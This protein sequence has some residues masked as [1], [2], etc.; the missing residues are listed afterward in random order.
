MSATYPRGVVDENEIMWGRLEMKLHVSDVYTQLTCVPRERWLIQ[1]GGTSGRRNSQHQE[2]STTREVEYVLHLRH[3]T[4]ILVRDFYHSSST[5]M[6]TG[7]SVHC[8][9]TFCHCGRM[10]CIIHSK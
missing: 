8:I 7:M 6:C 9:K 5:C 1:S 4:D 10:T 3:V 2:R